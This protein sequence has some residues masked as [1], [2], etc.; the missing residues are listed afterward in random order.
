M[1]DL[2]KNEISYSSHQSFNFLPYL[3]LYAQYSLLISVENKDIEMEPEKE[4][5]HN[6]LIDVWQVLPINTGI[7]LLPSKITAI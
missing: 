4:N 7:L 3:S 2:S 1:T 5:F 6:Y